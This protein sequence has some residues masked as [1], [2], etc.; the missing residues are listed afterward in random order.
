MQPEQARLSVS[1]TKLAEQ[2]EQ[3]M[4]QV[5]DVINKVLRRLEGA[6]IPPQQISAGHISLGPQ[7][8]YDDGQRHL[9]GF[10]ASRDLSILVRVAEVG[11]WLGRLAEAGV[12]EIAAPQ[13]LTLDDQALRDELYGLALADALT[14]AEALLP[15]GQT[16]GPVMEIS[17]L[18]GGGAPRAAMRESLDAGG[19]YVSGPVTEQVRL[20]VK[21][22]LN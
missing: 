7:Y 21:V 9:L 15:E 1:V 12:T 10:Q 18:G 8:R 19:R 22:A 13:Y 16:L 3:A 2:P 20:T 6:Q 14:R 11:H 5:D 17:E 4:S